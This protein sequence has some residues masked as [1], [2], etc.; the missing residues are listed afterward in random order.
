VINTHLWGVW[1][2]LGR[3]SADDLVHGLLLAEGA[4]RNSG[5]RKVRLSRSAKPTRFL[6]LG[7]EFGCEMGLESAP[8]R[9]VMLDS[10]L[11]G[12]MLMVLMGYWQ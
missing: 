1:P 2:D 8:A 5:A 10:M 9:L 12:W 3:S 6:D 4:T 11:T 7:A